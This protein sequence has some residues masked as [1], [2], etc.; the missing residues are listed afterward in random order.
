VSIEDDNASGAAPMSPGLYG[1]SAA[2]LSSPPLKH[3]FLRHLLKRQRRSHVTVLLRHLFAST[4][5]NNNNQPI[6]L[7]YYF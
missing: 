6:V 1:Y 3:A 7:Y 2:A 5:L 4:G